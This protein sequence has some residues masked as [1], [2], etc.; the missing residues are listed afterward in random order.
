[1]T[2]PARCGVDTDGAP[3]AGRA[4]GPARLAHVPALDGLRG[5]AALGVLLYH[6]GVAA[7]PGGFLGVALFFVLSGYLITALL[8]QERERTG[9]VRLGAFWARRARRLLPALVLVL[10]AIALLGPAAAPDGA[11]TASRGDV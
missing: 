2:S 10:A 7:V 4:A 8:V 3:S 1:M 6:G 5:V 9:R 11:A